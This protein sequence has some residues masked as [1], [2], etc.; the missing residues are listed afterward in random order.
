MK[1]E[2]GKAKGESR[3]HQEKPVMDTLRELMLKEPRMTLA[4]AES[5]TSGR[6]QAR[7]GAISGASDFFL[8]GITAYSLGQKVRHLG[9]SR[10]LAEPVDSVSAAVAEQMAIGACALFGADLAVATTGY[11]EPAPAK[12]VAAPFAWWAV[13]LRPGLEPALRLRSGQ[14][15]RACGRIDCPGASRSEAQERVAEAALAALLV[16]LREIRGR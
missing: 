16:W 11:A 1:G 12:S 14:A 2:S 10:E 4:A 6:I 7:V 3:K 8:G 13:A 15:L 9:V 5:M